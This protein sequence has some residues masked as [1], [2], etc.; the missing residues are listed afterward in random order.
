MRHRLHIGFTVRAA[1]SGLFAVLIAFGCSQ[2]RSVGPAG[3][4]GEL[5]DQEVT[6][7]AISETDAGQLEWKLY[8][9]DAATYTARNLIVAHQV[10][11]DF[12]DAKG[13]QSSELVANQGEI[14]QRT[15]N[16]TARGRVVLQTTEG[17]RLSSEELRFLNKQQKIVV[18]DDQLVRVQ[19]GGD[20][21]TGYGFESDPNLTRFEFKR[22]V[23]A[24]VRTRRWYMAER[25]RETEMQQTALKLHLT[26]DFQEA[27]RAFVEKR[28][29]RPF[30][31]R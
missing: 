6:D 31:G 11:I 20:V 8:A 9:R 24:T 23:Q 30:K 18:P 3:M 4:S 2:K 27:A 14:N 22:R 12:Y 21:L 13:S 15:R 25:G 19:R 17:T 16:M 29:P 10:R 1:L 7:F 5:P 28:Q 26:E